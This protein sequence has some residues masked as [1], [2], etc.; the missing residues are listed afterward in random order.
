MACQVPWLLGEGFRLR[1]SWNPGHPGV[2]K[3]GR[4]MLPAIFGS[5][6]YQLN[7][8]IGTLLASFLPEGSVSWLYYADRLVQFPLGVFAIAVSTA[9]LP[10]LSRHAAKK[11]MDHFGNTVNGALKL[12]FF[13]TLPSM[14]G[15]MVLGKPIIAVLFER[16]AFGSHATDMTHLA[17]LGYAAGLL[18][19]SGMRVLIA[20]LY[21]V[22]DTRT[23]VRVA[24]V[25][26]LANVIFSL[27]LMKPLRHGG[28][29]VALSMSSYVQFLLLLSFLRKKRAI[30][31]GRALLRCLMTSAGCATAM[32]L[33]VH[34]FHRLCLL[35][36]PDTFFLDKTVC[37]AIL[38]IT[39]IGLYMGLAVLLRCE[40]VEGLWKRLCGPM[41]N[42]K[43][44]RR[45]RPRHQGERD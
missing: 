24:T 34:G 28:L 25:A 37:V 38:V 21:A 44:A 22:Q 32:G 30:G 1:P 3:I 20:A 16:G 23:P 33:G 27:A 31:D 12:V 10:S 41:R 5:A 7:Q 4:L 29:A 36:D 39:G 17:L 6:V 14:A 18:A 19:F 9:A 8:F 15:L 11:E 2:K 43:H 35:M 13:I 40:E 26:L 45:S 42:A